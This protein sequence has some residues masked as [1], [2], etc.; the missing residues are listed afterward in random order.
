[1]YNITNVTGSN[2]VV[3]LAQGTDQ[4]L[5]GHIFGYFTLFVIIFTLFI[6]LKSRGY[7]PAASFAVGCFVSTFIALLLRAMNLLDNYTFWGMILLCGVSICMLCL[8]G[9]SD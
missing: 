8:A 9:N 1:M 4:I 2:G 5:G 6:A 7:H 3:A